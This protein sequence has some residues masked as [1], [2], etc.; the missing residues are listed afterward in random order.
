[1]LLDCIKLMNWQINE[2]VDAQVRTAMRRLHR[3]TFRNAW[4]KTAR[5]TER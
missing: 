3:A 4:M 1:M 5:L 2:S